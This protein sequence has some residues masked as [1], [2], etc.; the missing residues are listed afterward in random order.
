MRDQLSMISNMKYSKCTKEQIYNIIEENYDPITGNYK[1][2]TISNN[3]SEGFR[4]NIGPFTKEF[5]DLFFFPEKENVIDGEL[6]DILHEYFAEKKFANDS[7]IVIHL[8][9]LKKE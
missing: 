3:T 9:S 4:L 2:Y 1:R 5:S 6:L 7:A 8:G